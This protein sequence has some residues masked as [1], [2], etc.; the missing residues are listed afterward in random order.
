MF[1]LISQDDLEFAQSME[2]ASLWFLYNLQAIQKH[3]V[4]SRNYQM[5]HFLVALSS[6]TSYHVGLPSTDHSTN[7]NSSFQPTMHFGLD[8]DIN[9][10]G[11]DPITKLIQVG[12]RRSKISELSYDNPFSSFRVQ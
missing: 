9:S 2:F 10:V 5:N 8:L 7:Q 6:S 3:L 12:E 4:K 11:N 1:Q